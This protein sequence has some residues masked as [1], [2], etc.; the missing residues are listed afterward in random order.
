[1]KMQIKN[2]SIFNKKYKLYALLFSIILL[3]FAEYSLF[4]YPTGLFEDDTYFYYTI[5]YN[6]LIK[7]FITFDGINSTNGFHPLW[8]F[9]LFICGLPLKLIGIYNPSIYGFIFNLFSVFIWYLIFFNLRNILVQFL[10]FSFSLLSGLGMEGG[11]AG[12]IIIQIFKSYFNEEYQS[13]NWLFFP[14]VLTRIDL[15]ITAFFLS[16]KKIKFK[17]FW[18]IKPFLIILLAIFSTFLLN[19]IIDGSIFSISSIL[20]SSEGNLHPPIINVLNNL[21]QGIGNYV[22]YTFVFTICAILFYL[23]FISKKLP[24]IF[25]RKIPNTYTTLYLCASSLSFLIFHTIFGDVRDWYFA[26]TGISLIFLLDNFLNTKEFQEKKF[27]IFIL[28][29][30]LSLMLTSSFGYLIKERNNSLLAKDFTN[31]VTNSIPSNSRIYVVDGSG[32]LGWALLPN[33]NVINGDGLVNSFS[34]YNMIKQ[35]RVD[36]FFDY[37]KTNKIEYYITNGHFGH[38]LGNPWIYRKC[39]QL[40]NNDDIVIR[41]KNQNGENV[42]II[43]GEEILRSKSKRKFM[44]YKLNKYPLS[45]F[46]SK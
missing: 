46:N 17:T 1:M 12:L 14:L 21:N 33:L 18:E 30:L 32:Y 39:D 45:I 15:S 23:I 7:G 20:K 13:K 19:L 44:Q 22:R 34:Y 16:L 6:S 29:L 25:N 38:C 36:L 42:E 8:M 40:R 10:A 28:V 31:Q 24:N 2:I 26:P 4:H 11:L 41:I 3:F 35:G 27:I 43:G 9:L 5:T 37:L